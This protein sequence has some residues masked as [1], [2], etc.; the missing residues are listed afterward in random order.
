MKKGKFWTL[1]PLIRVC[2]GREKETWIQPRLADKNTDS[3]CNIPRMD[4]K[5]MRHELRFNNWCC[6]WKSVAN[7]Y[8]CIFF[9]SAFLSAEEESGRLPAALISDALSFPLQQ[10]RFLLLHQ[11]CF[12]PIIQSEVWWQ[13]AASSGVLMQDNFTLFLSYKMIW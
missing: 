13:T 7:A 4:S 11:S 3:R 5:L 1:S 6:T 2:G 10:Q 9:Y 12:Q 8:I